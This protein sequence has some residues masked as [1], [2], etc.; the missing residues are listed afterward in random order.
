[1]KFKKLLLASIFVLAILT[2]GCASASQNSTQNDSATLQNESDMVDVLGE[3]YF[4]D[5]DFYMTV[6]ENY[7][8]DL[9]DWDS[10]ELIYISSNSQKNGTFKVSVDDTEKLSF[11]IT[12]GYFSVE[13]DGNG[14]TYNKYY[15]Y[16]CPKDIGIENTGSY[17]IIIRF[18]DTTLIDTPVTLK[19]KEDFD[20]WMQNPYYCEEEYWTAPSFIAIDSNHL[21]NGVLEIYVNGTRKISYAV[22]DGE[23]E[24]IADCSNKSRYLSPSDLFEGYGT[25][26]IQIN[27]TQNGLT[28]M[29]RDENVVVAE[30][31]PTVNP[32]IEVYFEFDNLYLR[33]DTHAYIYLPREATGNLTISYNGK[34][35][36]VT[37]S[38][39][40]GTHYIKDYNLNHLGENV[41]TVNYEG[42]D[43]KN[44][45]V[46]GVINVVPGITCPDFVSVGEEFTFSAVVYDWVQYGEFRV[47]DDKGNIINASRFNNGHSSVKLSSNTSGSNKFN[48]YFDVGGSGTYNLTKEVYV[49]K[50][51]ENINAYVPDEVEVGSSFNITINAPDVDFT[52]A[53]VSVDGGDVEFLMFKSGEVKKTIT[54]LT[55]G[56]HTIK[57][58]CDNSYYAEGDWIEDIYLNTFTVNAGVKTNITVSDLTCDYG[59][60]L[61]IVLK[62]VNGNVLSGKELAINVDGKNYTKTTD[63]NGQAIFTVNLPGGNYTANIRFA[64]DEGYLSSSAASKIS[65]NKVDVDLNIT[66][67]PLFYG[68]TVV[69]TLKDVYGNILTDKTIFLNFNATEYNQTTNEIGQASF[70]LGLVPGNYT[71]NI[72]FK[73]DTGYN[74]LSRNI[75]VEMVRAFVFLEDC[76]GNL[77][78]GGENY[79]ILDLV[80]LNNNLSLAKKNVI[81]NFNGNDTNLTSD[82]NGF[83][84]FKVDLP[85]GNYSANLRMVDDNLFDVV[86]KGTFNFTIFRLQTRMSFSNVVIY[87]TKTGHMIATLEDIKG[88]HLS[89]KTLMINL[90]GNNYTRFTNSSGQ[91][92]VFFEFNRSNCS[93][94][95]SFAGDENYGESEVESNMTFKLLSILTA[96]NVTVSY[97]S[98]GKLII[99][100]SDYFGSNLSGKKINIRLA[101]QNITKITDLNGQVAIPINLNPGMYAA[102]I[103]FE[104]DDDIEN[105][106]TN[107]T[108]TVTKAGTVLTAAHINTIY[109]VAKNLIITLKDADGKPLSLK[110]VYVKIGEKT[111]DAVTDN[112]GNA[113]ISINLPVNSYT[114][115]IEFKGDECYVKSS[116]SVKIIVSKAKPK[117]IAKSKTFKLKTKNKKLKVALKDNLGR[118]MKNTKLTLKVKG[119]KYIAKSNK[120]GVVTF[121]IKLNKKGSFRAKISFKGNSNYKAVSKTV[122]IKVKR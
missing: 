18:N 22:T 56:Y 58:F 37:Y 19:E 88:N 33:A 49:I 48:L 8:Q 50:N 89:N 81:I 92:E 44:L 69:V 106:S 110:N 42:N 85:A 34:S 5:D 95:I 63:N 70:D 122:K 1:M 24:E 104:G 90:N 54:F 91:A 112:N 82:E 51:S 15:R 6:N 17:N 28:E 109:N 46:T 68:D 105:S 118:V 62:D 53:Q 12:N 121:K 57:V 10:N 27:F 59:D 79:V 14:G 23:F 114:A 60:N 20:I 25:Y 115:E 107:A 7:S 65:V 30:F 72:T 74:N 80:N 21:T 86:D 40:Y 32:K 116:V 94:K 67:R 98:G 35:F 102:Y 61:T 73:G 52:F 38:K 75:D 26:R 31:E 13:D 117:L 43:F 2:I 41:V 29:L 93:L 11:N 16:I 96:E 120:K 111:L 113:V 83:V 66:G 3:G 84:R 103:D 97:N 76:S 87:V 77:F 45:N 39:G 55:T 64:G 99:S 119:K 78:Y 71:F 108:V 36:P 4:C 47:S 101:G 9:S 100:L